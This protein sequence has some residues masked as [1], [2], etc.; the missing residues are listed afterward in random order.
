[1][2]AGKAGVRI[3]SREI[4][5]RSP[6]PVLLAQGEER[7]T[8][9]VLL[10]TAAGEPGKLDVLLGAQLARSLG[11]RVT[12]LYVEPQEPA[13]ETT[14]ER[15]ARSWIERHL[16]QGLRTLRGQGVVAESRIR[17]GEALPEILAEVVEGDNDLVVIGAHREHTYLDLPERD[18]SAGL[19]NGVGRPVLIVKGK[20]DR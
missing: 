8:R 3:E 4:A 18:L 13:G 15:R 7:E 5:V 2:R 9:R 16:D 12:L 14:A 1:V 17:Y 6:V 11:A 20:I 10:C 19:I